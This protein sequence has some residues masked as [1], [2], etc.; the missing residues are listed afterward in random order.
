MQHGVLDL[1]PGVPREVMPAEGDLLDLPGAAVHRE[2]AQP[3]A[4]PAGQPDRD[5]GERAAEVLEVEPLVEVAEALQQDQVAGTRPVAAHRPE[6]RRRVLLDRKAEKLPL[7]QAA[8]GARHAR[9]EEPDDRAEDPVRRHGVAAMQ[10]QHPPGE[11]DHDGAVGVGE[12]PVDVAK[13]YQLEPVPEQLAH[14]RGPGRRR[15]PRRGPA[16]IPA[17]RTS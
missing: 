14:V 12:D 16:A 6:R 1:G 7:G 4:H 2:L 10:P 5:R 8:R 17:G 15:P 3:G 11:A 9:V 13:P